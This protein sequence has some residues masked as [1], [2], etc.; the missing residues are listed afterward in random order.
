[1]AHGIFETDLATKDQIK[2]TVSTLEIVT[3]NRT[4]LRTSPSV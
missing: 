1:M 2:K 4:A 3:E